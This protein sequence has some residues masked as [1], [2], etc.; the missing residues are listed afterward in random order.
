VIDAAA[1]AGCPPLVP[2]AIANS[3]GRRT[4]GED[5]AAGDGPEAF[6]HARRRDHEVRAVREVGVAT[7]DGQGLRVADG[8]AASGTD[9]RVVEAHLFERHDVHPAPAA[10]KPHRAGNLVDEMNHGRAGFGR[11]IAAAARSAEAPAGVE[12]VG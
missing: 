6:D 12:R 5:G 11:C 7:R 9:P 2:V 10:P 8:P 3:S 4:A 1:V